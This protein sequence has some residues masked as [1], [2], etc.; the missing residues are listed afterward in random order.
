MEPLLRVLEIAGEL[1]IGGS[2][3][4][5]EVRAEQLCRSLFE[6]MV[7]SFYEPGARLRRL[8]EEGIPVGV[9]HGD[10]TEFQK[11][12][13]RFAPH[14]V[15]Y[16]RGASRGLYFQNIHRFS[17]LAGVPVLIET[18]IF[19]RVSQ[20]GVHV[21]PNVVCHMSL[22]SMLRFSRTSAVTMADL[23]RQGDRAVYLPVPASRWTPL[24]I[25]PPERLAVR[26][27]LGVSE[28]DILACRMGRPDIRKW[29]T[30]L[31][32]ALPGIFAHV[33]NLRLLLMAAPKQ[34]EG[35]QRRFPGR[36][37][38]QPPSAIEAELTRMYQAADLMIHSSG[39]G[40]SFGL[41]IAEGMYWGLPVVVD[42][43]PAADN[44]QVELVDHGHTGFV[45][46]SVSGFIEGISR[47]AGDSNLRNR[48]GQAGHQKA[49]AR[50]IDSRVVPQWE[51]IYIDAVHAANP[52]LVSNAQREY[53]QDIPAL[54]DDSQY[55][56]FA[57]EYQ[58]RVEA[59][60]GARASN[61]EAVK[62]ALLRSA[63]TLSYVR[64]TGLN[65]AFSVA[66]SRCL[67]GSLFRRN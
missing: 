39:I 63:D 46:G 3:Q 55:E 48:M 24:R 25:S 7:V 36:V 18:N 65:A 8:E 40:E 26:S 15:H 17:R 56:S 31:E 30:R 1:G 61:A 51:K 47:L 66:V 29:S 11:I 62:H 50:Y 28:G 22:R 67:S 34:K 35:L 49:V 64:T 4:A 13:E 2:E 20:D 5:I 57:T 41:A 43:T 16:S 53:A 27:K 59:L 21:R 58:Q 54:P 45:V 23:W 9:C 19:G 12:L 33:P 44:A 52:S 10:W 6:V 32:M 42:S 37:I 14:I 60:L 38:L